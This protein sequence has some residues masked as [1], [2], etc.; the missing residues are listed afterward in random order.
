MEF[1]VSAGPGTESVLRDEL[2]ELGFKSARLNSG[3][4]PFT[5]SWEDG[6][7]ACLQTRIGQR[8]M[9]VLGRFEASGLDGVYDSVSAVDWAEFLTPRQTFAVS[10]YAHESMGV[11]PNIVALKAKDAIVDQQRRDY[12]E[13]SNVDR[14]S[15]DVRVF[16]YSA[17]QKVT[18][19]L[20]MSGE[21]LFKRG[22]RSLGGEAPLKETL[23][24]AMLRLS[25]WDREM[26]LVDPMCGS[27]TLPI[28]AALWAANIAPG[29]K[30]ERFGFER[31]ANFDDTA[32]ERMRLLRGEMRWIAHGKLPRV[33]G[34]DIDDSALS[35]AEANAKAAGLRLSFRKMPLRELQAD[36]TRRM[37]VANPPYGIRLDA[38]NALYQEL[39][40]AVHRLRGWRIAILAGSPRC[41]QAIKLSP[42]ATYPLKNGAIDCRLMV[43]EV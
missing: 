40:A 16:V 24:A 11:N 17:R 9:V 4:I 12:G 38:D 28:E 5:G 41:V 42:V 2:C 21:P 20:D 33:T 43:Y 19:Y 36:N 27:G 30:R 39:G 23:A 29:L 37:L 13:R 7:R 14:E 1:Y 6:W 18:V 26:P 3:G 34:F 25:G 15:P 10:A 22:Y 32:A 31:W 8:V 35:A